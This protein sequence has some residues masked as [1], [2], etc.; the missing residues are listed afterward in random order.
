LRRNNSGTYNSGVV[1]DAPESSYTNVE[2]GS[3][4]YLRGDISWNMGG[5]SET[6]SQFIA[7]I[8][9]TLDFDY[10]DALAL[11]VGAGFQFSPSWRL[12]FTAEQSLNSEFE[13]AFNVALNGLLLTDLGGGVLVQVPVGNLLGVETV[14][15]EYSAQNY[16]LNGYYDLPKFG[17]FTPYVGAGIGFSRINYQERRTV[18]CLPTVTQTCIQ[19][20]PGTQST[21]VLDVVVL[22]RDE[23]AFT[24]AYQAVIGTAYDLSDT[25][26]L[27][28]GYSYFRTG[29][30]PKLSYSDGTA[31]D[32]GGYSVQKVH[33]G[34]R[35]E[36][37]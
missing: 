7:D 4:W 10:E 16:L 23:T 9:N 6:G 12:D 8:G 3:G 20:T 1:R 35:Y 33:V 17:K 2:F 36:L 21:P 34:L 19:P 26:K 37:W 18:S 13:G 28:V 27:D 15:A 25:L 24:L 5:R 22:D 14:L 32:V 31:I 11:R 30:G 29:D